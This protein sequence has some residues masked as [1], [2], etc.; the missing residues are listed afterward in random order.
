MGL[1]DFAP[2]AFVTINGVP[3]TGFLFSQL[4]SIS[5]TDVAGLQ[6]DT[7]DLEFAGSGLFGSI[8]L[9][10]PGAEISVALGALGK[11][12]DFGV[13]IADECEETSPPSTIRVRGLAKPQGT[14]ASGMGPLH[15]QKSRSWDAGQTLGA[16]VEA[17]AGEAGLT[18][19]V[20]S[21]V[22]GLIL[23]HLDQ[24]DES[25]IALL[26]RVALGLD[27]LVKPSA[28]RL[29][30]GRRGDGLAASGRSMPI[31]PLV[32][33]NVSRWSVRRSLGERASSVVATYRDLTAAD[34]IEVT[35][36][37][38]E[39]VRR[40]RGTFIDQASARA[41]AEG[42]LARAERAVETL[43]VG[44]PGNALISP[45]CIILPV[46]SLASAGRWI[47]AEVRHSLSSGGFITSFT[48]ERANAPPAEG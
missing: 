28:G 45:E 21:S 32:R 15:V 23:G 16:L 9:P 41:A 44:M 14:T 36:G 10:Q 20:A 1:G 42:E 48:A 31:F 37:S 35:A 26:T 47:A 29:F 40:L 27:V 6:S 38:G 46:F 18:P 8:A 4:S 19:A 12:R 43:E 7:V 39:P 5:V 11:V 34:E 24:I 30:V 3:L 13:F 2:L 33:S 17:I 25:D 22:A